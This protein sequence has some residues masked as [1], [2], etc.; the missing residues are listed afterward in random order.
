MNAWLLRDSGR[1]LA[2]GRVFQ[3]ANFFSKGKGKRGAN[4]RLFLSDA[5]WREGRRAKWSEKRTGMFQ[6]TEGFKKAEADWTPSAT[7]CVLPR[8]LFT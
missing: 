1:L 2:A 7:L 3:D 5:L 6:R 8:F 4:H